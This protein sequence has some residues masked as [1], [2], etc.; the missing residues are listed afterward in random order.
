MRRQAATFEMRVVTRTG[1]ERPV[2]LMRLPGGKRCGTDQTAHSNP[3]EAAVARSQYRHR[4]KPLSL[5]GTVH[6][7]D[8]ESLDLLGPSSKC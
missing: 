4:L 3:R 5:L 7:K 1:P 8:A 6:N 2:S